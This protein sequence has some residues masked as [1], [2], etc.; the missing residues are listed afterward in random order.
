MYCVH[1]ILIGWGVGLVGHRRLDLAPVLVAMV[2]VLVLTD[3]LTATLPFLRGSRPGVD[4]RSVARPA[5]A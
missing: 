5:E 4:S 3:R 1:W 2:V